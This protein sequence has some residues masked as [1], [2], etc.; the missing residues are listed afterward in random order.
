MHLKSLFAIL[1]AVSTVAAAQSPS[2][3]I[4]RP[5]ITGIS[6]LAVYTSDGAAADHFYCKVVGAARL[7]D[8]EDPKGVRY[9]FSDM[10]FVEVLPLPA[11][12][13]INRLDH[14]AFNT[15]GLENAG[16]GDHWD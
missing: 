15:K 12:T 5:K 11:G 9:A 3:S 8:P 2:S 14:V 4:T 1:L 16:Q 10:Q 7:T 13:G 6:H